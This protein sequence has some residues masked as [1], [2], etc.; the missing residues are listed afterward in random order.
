MT[1]AEHDPYVSKPG[2]A[3][4]ADRTTPDVATMEEVICHVN[5]HAPRTFLWDYERSRPQLVTLYNKASLRLCGP[6]ARRGVSTGSTSDA[7]QARKHRC[8]RTPW[9]GR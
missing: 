8:K 1:M 3:N 6:Y 5:D 7:T 2:D 9:E 4:T